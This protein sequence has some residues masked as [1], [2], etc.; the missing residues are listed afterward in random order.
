MRYVV[1][2]SIHSPIAGDVRTARLVL[3]DVPDKTSVADVA[4][5]LTAAG[6]AAEFSEGGV[7]YGNHE[8]KAEGRSGWPKGIAEIE[9]AP[10]LTWA[11]LVQPPTPGEGRRV[12]LRLTPAEHATFTLAA[13]RAGVS[14]QTWCMDA[15]TRAATVDQASSRGRGDRAQAQTAEVTS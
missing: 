3:A 9:S 8:I 5:A 2:R 11:R 10:V 13:Q 15:L 14:L 4:E 1:I 7:L 6:R 12:T